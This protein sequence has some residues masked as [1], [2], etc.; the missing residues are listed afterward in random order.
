MNGSTY[1]KM[2]HAPLVR[3]RTE[4]DFEGG[5][6]QSFYVQLEYNLAPEA[7]NDDDWTQIACFDHQP[8]H[9]LGHD[10]TREGLHMDIRH[11]AKRDRK[12]VDFPAVDLADAPRFC[13]KYLD[14]NYREI[15]ARYA[16]WSNQQS[17]DWAKALLP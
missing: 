8:E 11:P 13:E 9:P 6:I 15:S 10:I 1:T 17:S 7:S 16:G 4:L 5:E 12:T 14:K 3:R 2:L